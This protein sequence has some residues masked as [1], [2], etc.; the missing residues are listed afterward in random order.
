MHTNNMNHNDRLK[1]LEF[2]QNIISRMAKCSFYLKELTIAVETAILAAFTSLQKMSILLGGIIITTIFWILDSHYLQLERGF[3]HKY[4][5][6]SNIDKPLDVCH[7]EACLARKCKTKEEKEKLKN[8]Y[9]CKVMFSWS[10]LLLYL[11]IIILLSIGIIVCNYF[12]W[13]W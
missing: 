3:R 5:Q 6:E 11:S 9:F 8:T 13:N 7:I 4:N 12:S 10:E 2:I 1:Y